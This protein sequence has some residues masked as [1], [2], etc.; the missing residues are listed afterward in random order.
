MPP[1]PA[2]THIPSA[3]ACCMQLRNGAD[4]VAVNDNNTAETSKSADQSGI[5]DI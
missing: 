1:D 4:A 2:L 5:I 3:A